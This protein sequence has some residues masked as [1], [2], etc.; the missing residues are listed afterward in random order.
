MF[1]RDRAGLVGVRLEQHR[2]L[3]AQERVR[4]EDLA[5][6]RGVRHVDVIGLRAGRAFASQ[7]EH[8]G[9]VR[10]HDAA[11]R[12]LRQGVGSLDRVHLVEVRRH[13]CQALGP[14]PLPAAESETEHVPVG[15]GVGQ[16]EGGAGGGL[17]R[18]R[19]RRARCPPPWRGSRRGSRAGA[20]AGER[21]DVAVDR[22]GCESVAV[23]GRRRLAPVRRDP[24]RTRLR[25]GPLRTAFLDRS[26]T[27][28]RRWCSMSRCG[29]RTKDRLHQARTRQSG[30]ITES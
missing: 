6:L 23:A 1:P 25:R 7:L 26:P 22:V 2:V 13:G 11:H 21:A 9:P 4:P 3:D 12:S 16:Q 10:G 8:F 5:R 19:C 17:R 14:R 20:R 15:V 30:R 27:R 24:A 18:R 28:N 29:N